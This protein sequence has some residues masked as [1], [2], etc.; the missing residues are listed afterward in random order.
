MRLQVL[1]V[2]DSAEDME[3]YVRDLPG[4]FESQG[5]DVSIDPKDTFESGLDAAKNPLTRYD[6]VISDTYRGGHD[7]RD[8]AVLVMIEEYRRGKFCPLIVMSSGVCPDEFEE[9]PFVRWASKDVA[10]NLE[11]QIHSM[12]QTGIPQTARKLHDEL[13]NAAGDF[14]WGFIEANWET[15]STDAAEDSGLIE[16]IVRRRAA[17]AL[18]DLI[19]SEYAALNSRYGLEYYVYPALNH[20]YYSL[21]DILVD[22]ESASDFRVIM[23][24]HCH[25]FKQSNQVAPR[26]EHVLTIKTVAASDVLGEK[27]I[28]A[29]QATEAQKDKKLGQWARSPALTGKKPDGRHWYLPKFLEIPHLYCDFLQVESLPLAAL[30][31]SYRRVATLLPPYAE[32]F[33]ECFSSF[34]GS[35]GIPDIEPKAIR[36]IIDDTT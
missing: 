3:Q 25:L 5:Y 34:Y 9:T 22:N 16:R 28:N 15:L 1:L 24:P 20:D 30:K 18:S 10:R 27:I 7:N 14:L 32:A 26:A 19:P 11:E 4:I 21:G 17:I 8:T 31:E 2:E 13:D 36:D 23:T 12:L 6:L 35:V 29:K 33:Q